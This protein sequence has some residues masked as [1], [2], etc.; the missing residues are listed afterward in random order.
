[1][2]K[3][4]QL[5]VFTQVFMM[6]ANAQDLSLYKPSFYAEGKDTMPY[7]IL[8]PMDYDSTKAYPL[9]L[10]LHGAGDR[11]N[12]NRKQLSKGGSLFV[13]DEV[14]KNYPAFV[15]FPQCSYMSFWST[16]QLGYD[17]V[18]KRP[19]MQFP[20]NGKPT[21][22]ME[23]LEG[24][25]AH[26]LETLPVKK[27]QVYVGGLSMGGMG[28]YEIVKR[29][30]GIFAAAFPICG[31]ANAAT[32]PNLVNAS[33]WVFHGEKDPLVSFHFSKDMVDALKREGAQVKFT[34]YPNAVHNSW[35]KA[36]AEPGLL[37]WLF[38]QRFQNG[39]K[40]FNRQAMVLPMATYI[41]RTKNQQDGRNQKKHR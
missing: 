29:M 1:M 31:A 5:L 16:L 17:T 19:L 23:L 4:F 41:C 14:R 30:P 12:D 33:W 2:I 24:M 26:L 25:T 20:V 36:F 27:D 38:S 32:A 18:T 21:K 39:S 35:D 6:M 15:V 10:F 28:T 37:P 34:A 7:R 8:Y 3:H 40:I 13:K 9:V 11:G 22:A